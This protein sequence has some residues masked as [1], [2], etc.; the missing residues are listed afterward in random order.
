MYQLMYTEIYS[1]IDYDYY[2]DKYAYEYGEYDDKS[3]SYKCHYINNY[4]IFTRLDAN[5]TI[6]VQKVISA[7]AKKQVTVLGDEC[8]HPYAHT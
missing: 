8:A 1:S 7:S 2:V 5:G 3:K 4:R 6:H